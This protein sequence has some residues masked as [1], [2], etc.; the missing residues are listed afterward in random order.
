[1]ER[2]TWISIGLVVSVVVAF[3][4][5]WLVGNYAESR[6]KGSGFESRFPEKT[7]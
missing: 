7:L 4:M 5:C 3:G 1:M 2:G 6:F